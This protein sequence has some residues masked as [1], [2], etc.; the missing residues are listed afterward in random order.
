[1]WREAGLQ[2]VVFLPVQLSSLANSNYRNHRKLAIVDGEVAFV[3]GMNISD[4]YRNAQPHSCKGSA[5]LSGSR[6]GK[7]APVRGYWRDTSVRLQGPC[8]NVLQTYF[9]LDWHFADG[10][11]YDMNEG[12]LHI[13]PIRPVQ[14]GAIVSVACSDPGSP[15]NSCMETLL[16]AISEAQESIRLCTP[17]FI[18]SEELSTALQIAAASGIRV[19]LMIPKY[20]DSYIVQHAS[21]S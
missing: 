9:W 14:D 1:K 16:V 11:E 21:T 3:G 7:S 8:V 19:E 10:A 13:R 2:M 15:A 4:Y 12:Y 6:P 17:Y 5:A 18:P 20:G